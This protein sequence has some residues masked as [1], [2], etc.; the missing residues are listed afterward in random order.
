ME[1]T[2]PEELRRRI[3]KAG[4]QL[5]HAHILC[6]AGNREAAALYLAATLECTAQE[7]P[8]LRCNAC[9]KV[10]GQIHPD[11]LRVE[12]RERR[13]LSAEQLRG[14]VTEAGILPNE[15]RHKVFLFPDCNQLDGRGQD[16]LLKTV[17]EG[18]SYAVFLFCAESSSQL[19][20]TLRSRCVTWQVTGGEDTAPSER[21]EA[22]CRML[23]QRSVTAAAEWCVAA[24]RQKLSREDADR[25]FAEGWRAC[26]EAMK[27]RRGGAAAEPWH[28]CASV[29]AQHLTQKQLFA[30]CRCFT[31]CRRQCGRNVGIGL[32]L[33]GFAAEWETLL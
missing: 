1:Q 16:I 28:S 26:A 2:V 30:L 20:P 5:T 4:G 21:T 19:L 23:A 17:E 13:F 32:I 12:D 14:V 11:V 15:G 18:A 6:G 10:F 27:L 24:E 29:L 8:C 7:R 33:G 25:L 3:A 31:V 9:R 22:L